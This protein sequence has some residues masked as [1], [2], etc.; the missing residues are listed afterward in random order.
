MN[1]LE[2]N[3]EAEFDKALAALLRE[4]T[5]FETAAADAHLAKVRQ[6]LLDRLGSNE[7]T[8]FSGEAPQLPAT[9]TRRRLTLRRVGGGALG[10]AA[11]IAV[12]LT[13]LVL[14]SPAQLSAMDKLAARLREVQSY[15]YQLRWQ[16]T[17][18]AEDG[19][20]STTWTGAGPVYWQA[21]SALH[22]EL[23]IVKRQDDLAA[24]THTEEVLEHFLQIFP[25]GKLG[26]FIDHPQKTFR[27]LPFEP[28]GSVTYPWEPLRT[29]RENRG[30]ITR[31]LGTRQFGEVLA[32]GYVIQAKPEHGSP[33][34]EPVEVWVDAKTDLPLRFEFR[35][36]EANQTAITEASD[37]RWNIPLDAKLF[38]PRPPEGY[39][40]ITPPSE[41]NDLERIAGALRLY[42]EL[43]GGK[44][45]QPTKFETATVRTEM[46]AL[47]G[48]EGADKCAAQS[49]FEIRSN[50]RGHQRLQV[51]REDLAKSLPRR[52]SGC[53]RWTA[54]QGQGAVVVARVQT[55]P[56]SGILWRFAV[57]VDQRQT[58]VSTRRARRSPANTLARGCSL[59]PQ[60]QVVRVDLRAGFDQQLDNFA[61]PLGVERGFHLHRFERKQLLADRHRV[62]Q[63]HRYRD[64]QPRHGGANL[65]RVVA[66]G[67]GA[68]LFLGLQLH[69]ADVDL[70]GWPLSSKNTVRRPSGC[71]SPTVRNLTISVLP[72]SISTATSW[73]GSWP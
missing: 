2:Q 24:G 73:P 33:F 41:Q 32:R 28:T 10:L 48:L 31:E 14:R 17:E 6:T 49:R 20:R 67:L 30:Q 56:D 11:A 35:K 51:D 50:R 16:T 3:N 4:G 23:K 36:Q 62:A 59:D 47:A 52:I 29:I 53:Q 7:S 68:K 54:R 61:S 40:D 5:G 42:A 13:L 27:R 57:R 39:V 71:G 44:Y 15:S 19:K 38:E 69:V 58:V 60:Q 25:A 65:H 26:V 55:G 12:A 37:F 46:L 43:S 1:E 8:S 18:V 45:P 9:A 22:E 64:D 21:P 70:R 72:R 63:L 34:S 66:V